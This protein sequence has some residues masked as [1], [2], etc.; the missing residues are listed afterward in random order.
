MSKFSID[1]SD[2]DNKV[3][4][5]V[6]KLSEVKDKIKKVAFDVVRFK[7][8]D[9]ASKLWQIQSADDGDY[10]VALYDN[11]EDNKKVSE[12][13]VSLNKSASLI[14]VFYKGE[15]IV[16]LASSKLGVPSSEIE[17]AAE[18]LPAKLAQNKK[19]VNALLKEV[20][21]EVKQ[22]ILTKYPELA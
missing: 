3:N 19:L 13:E 15:A 20:K 21:E 12:W 7:D 4:K 18:Y 2:L 9:D 10:I 11:S 22:E 8:D 17:L 6:Y 16:R 5:K 14:D 1:Y